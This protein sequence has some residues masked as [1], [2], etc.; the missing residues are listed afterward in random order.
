M[1]SPNFDSSTPQDHKKNFETRVQDIARLSLRSLFQILVGAGQTAF[2]MISGSREMSTQTIGA[3]TLADNMS[4][5]ITNT[6]IGISAGLAC[7]LLAIVA[8]IKWLMI[9]NAIREVKS[10]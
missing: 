1:V 9:S 6:A 10:P 4:S 7:F 8:L 2:G 3:E 5:A